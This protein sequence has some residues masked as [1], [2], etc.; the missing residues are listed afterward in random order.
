MEAKAL[1]QPARI[2]LRIFRTGTFTIFRKAPDATS[3]GSPVTTVT[4]STAPTTWTDSDV[5]TGVMYEY[6]VGLET[7]TF[8]E[9]HGN[10]LAGI[11]VDRT[12]PRGRFA[13]VVTE[14]VI[15]RLPEEYARYKEG[16]TADGWMVHE[17]VV[18]R[19][20][21]LVNQSSG[22]NALA[23]VTVVSGGTGY[24]S[25]QQ[26]ILSDGSA[27]AACTITASSGVITSVAVNYGN[28][29]FTV[30]QPLAMSGHTTG[31]GAAL[32]VASVRSGTPEHIHIRN[33]IISLYNQFPG[34]LKNV[35]LIG[36]VPVARS[37]A[38]HLGPDGHG[39]Q[40][41]IGADAY[42]ADMDGV[43]TDTGSNLGS[44]PAGAG[45]TQAIDDGRLNL[46]GDN[47]FDASYL[48]QISTP[49]ARVEIGFG[50]ID[51]SNS[52]PAEYEALR[53]YF[54]KLHRY[55]T[56]APDFRPGRKVCNRTA[57]Y[58]TGDFVEIAL[59]RNMAGVVGMENLVLIRDAELNAVPRDSEA[60]SEED[61]DAAYTRA[62]GPFLFYFRGSSPPRRSTNSR[63]VFWTG[64]QSYWGYWF[65][66]N[67]TN[68]QNAM[69]ARLGEEN[70]SLSYTWS[71]WGTDYL[72]HRL[73]M[74]SDMGEMMRTTMNDRYGLQPLYSSTLTTPSGLFMNHMGCPSLRVFLFEPP[75]AL[76]VVPLGG[77][78]RL[79]WSSSPAEGVIGYH[80]YRSSSS[81]GPFVRMT[82]EPIASTTFTDHGATSGSWHYQVKAVR[83]ETSGG[84]TFYNPSLAVLGSIDLSGGGE[85]LQIPAITLPEGSW[86]TPYRASVRAIGGTPVYSWSVV[87]GALPPGL[88]LNASGEI[89]G[90][91]TAAG[92]ATFTVAVADQLG[93][94]A[95]RA[96]ELTTGS[97][98]VVVLPAEAAQYVSGFNTRV[99][100]F[101]E[102]TMLVSGPTYQFQ[103]FL[104]F[105][106]AGI[107]ERNHLARA[108][109]VLTV[110]EQ[111]QL[112]SI[113]LLQAALTNDAQDN[114]TER[115]LTH[116]TRPLDTTGVAPVPAASFPV[117]FGTVEF[118]V[119]PLVRRTLADDSARKL[120]LRIF[121]TTGAAFG[122]E[123]QFATRYAS[124]SASPRLIVESSDAPAISILSPTRGE[125]ALFSGSAL[126][127][128]ASATAIPSRAGALSVL[129]STVSGPASVSFGSPASVSTTAS[130]PA[131]GTYVVRLTAGDG[132]LS[133]FRDLTVRVLSVP[134]NTAPVFGADNGLVLRLPFDESAGTTATDASGAANHGTLATIGTSGAPAWT[135]AARIG[136]A[137]QFDGGGQRVEVNDSATN[138]LDG[139]Q[140]LTAS[141]W[142]RLN[143]QASTARAIL[144]KRTSATASTTSYALTLTSAR[145]LSASI[146]NKTALV[147]DNVLAAGQW[148]HVAMVFD[149]SKATDNL[150]I[151][152]NGSPEKLGTVASQPTVP[153]ITASRLRVGDY[154]TTTP[155]SGSASWDGQ[156]DEVR[157]YNR[158]LTLAEI[159]ELAVAA[160]ENVGP[161]LTVP[162]PI[163]GTSG[164]AF[165]LTGTVT[166]DGSP[167][168]TSVNWTQVT[169]PGLTTFEN[170]T[171]PTTSAF[172][173]QAGGYVLRFSASD[174]DITTWA[175]VSVSMEAAAD[176]YREWL[177]DNGLPADG[178]GNGAPGAAPLG[179]GVANAIKCALGI[180]L[181][182]RGYGDRL[183]TAIVTEQSSDFLSLTFSRPDPALAGIVY[184][185]K[186]SSDLIHWSAADTAEVSSEVSGGLRTITVRDTEAIPSSGKRFIRLEIDIP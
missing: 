171:Q 47:K 48:W 186:T 109:L 25:G 149:G 1:E 131:P 33:Q 102:P 65:Y 160:P 49:N 145:R 78:P 91:P 54:D 117:P 119:T 139:M 16:L 40:A 177:A 141:A 176:A 165:S 31:S 148:Y 15:A 11:K 41:A 24:T 69:A 58:P 128:Q 98:E 32:S 136:G 35:V 14:D 155:S 184:T 86:N 89:S 105:D 154:H 67:G 52:I 173:N 150:Q 97:N 172:V 121:T 180:P 138:P 108:R 63:A 56:A 159:R 26:V 127:I 17:I 12:L 57:A 61:R 113:S 83:L 28:A 5:E 157:L 167:A 152:L 100:A 19:A 111:S 166:D 4:A 147:G 181:Q 37:G 146:A 137:L 164:E 39:N 76:S 125:A 185:V 115:T 73:G 132:I 92:T 142:I 156:I 124:G 8:P 112:N 62:N 59:L 123:V 162:P 3:W 151:Y 60:L 36:R 114:W 72:Y 9:L 13:V 106:L 70:M 46:P 44:Y 134:I 144:V 96:L 10:V 85:T 179:D 34:E 27:Q 170:P 169:G 42:Y 80:V 122:N 153:R 101:Y 68:L 90:T 2:E 74:G 6:G 51:F 81:E 18:P 118:D 53:T 140:Q 130:F 120:G 75:S 116:A 135:S 30:G 79:S 21:D 161:R 20:P 43:W 143:S 182:T 38:S 178:T 158:A 94:T 50:R 168:P 82:S 133:S 99:G 175:D 103:S 107:T 55:R 29:G 93:A 95:H 45:R 23:G 7:S 22:T 64:L 87:A 88:S 84:G 71:I 66:P 163:H 129:W 183:S 104:R 126:A 110:D 77:K 174:G